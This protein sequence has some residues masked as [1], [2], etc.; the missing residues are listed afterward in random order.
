MGRK[1]KRK[2][3]EY[4]DRLGFNPW[5]YITVYSRSR[6]SHSSGRTSRQPHRGDVWYA[7]LGEHP[8]THVQSGCRPVL[9]V[10]NDIGNRYSETV[11]VLP[12]TSQMKRLDLSSHTQVDEQMM[13]GIRE[14]F[15]S[16]TVLAEQVTT[17]S[18]SQLRS[19]VGRITDAETVGKIDESVIQQLALHSEHGVEHDAPAA[20][21]M[22]AART[23]DDHTDETT[24][25]E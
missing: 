9:I 17:I 22:H 5:K 8:G 2:K 24:M 19:F 11:N 21:A 14:P 6:D 18:K 12:M 16:S 25:K 1:N 15:G 20:H 13:A 4:R 10:S 7:D 23:D 3:T